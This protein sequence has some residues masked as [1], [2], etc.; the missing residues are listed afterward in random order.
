[1]FEI[2]IFLQATLE[3][4]ETLRSVTSLKDFELLRLFLGID[5][6]DSIS[7]DEDPLEKP[8]EVSSSSSIEEKDSS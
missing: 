5:F 8:E 7:S 4:V 3:C 2:W 6:G 1:M